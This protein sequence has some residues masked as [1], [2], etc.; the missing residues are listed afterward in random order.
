MEARLDDLD[1]LLAAQ[2]IDLEISNLKKKLEGLPQPRTIAE[3][4]AKRSALQKKSGQIGALA[5]DA[6]KRLSR[7]ADEDASLAKKEKGVQTAIESAGGDY[8]NVEARTKE[9]A[10]IAKRRATLADDRAQVESERSRIGELE[11]Q[12]TAALGELDGIE[13]R[14]I[15]GYRREG[16]AL[17][18]QAALLEKQRDAVLA[19][20]D[21]QLV[22]EYRKTAERLGSIAVAELDGDH[23]SVCRSAIDGGRLIDLRNQAPLGTCPACT[24][25]LIIRTA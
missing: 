4:R 19:H 14:A 3:A 10:G 15:E 16:G 2:K 6:A 25:M 23:C 22:E 24:R 12:V 20:V 17:Q 8:R 11:S 13:E 21:G 18:Q 5:K 7:I 1:N 9:L